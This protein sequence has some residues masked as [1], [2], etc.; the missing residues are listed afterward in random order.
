MKFQDN[1]ICGF[2]AYD[3][4]VVLKVKQQNLLDAADADDK[5]AVY[6]YLDEVN[7]LMDAVYG[8][9]PDEPAPELPE[10]FDCFTTNSAEL[11]QS[12]LV[13]NGSVVRDCPIA[14][15]NRAFVFL[16][17]ETLHSIKK[18]LDGEI[19]RRGQVK[20]FDEAFAAMTGYKMAVASDSNRR[21]LISA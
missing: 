7:V 4:G 1:D 21:I 13:L 6:L 9:S 20:A 17:L 8:D 16:S 3:N 14:K 10:A 18:K 11:N 2:A 15:R 5:V 19:E 12:M